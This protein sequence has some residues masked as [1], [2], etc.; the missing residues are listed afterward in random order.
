MPHQWSDLELLIAS[1]RDADAFGEFYDRYSAAIV[2]FLRRRGV[3]YELALDLAAETFVPAFASLRGFV[4]GAGDRRA[5]LFG[6]ARHKLADAMNR[7]TAEERAHRALAMHPDLVDDE[8]STPI[9]PIASFMSSTGLRSYRRSSTTR[10][11]PTSSTGPPREDR[12]KLG[13]L[14]KRGA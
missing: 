5:W 14:G 10:S 12:G 1:Q 4:P 6:I 3:E 7:Q 11:S 2:A 8:A 9:D 13:V